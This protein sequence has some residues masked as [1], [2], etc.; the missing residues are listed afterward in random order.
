[1]PVPFRNRSTI[2]NAQTTFSGSPRNQ[3]TYTT[4]L[5]GARRHQFDTLAFPVPAG[6]PTVAPNEYVVHR[7]LSFERTFTAVNDTPPTATASNNYASKSV[8]NGSVIRNLQGKITVRNRS[9]IGGFVSVYR[10]ALSFYD[11]LIWDTVTPTTCPFT[12]DSTT[13]GP[14]DVRGVVAPKTVNSTRLA[15][16]NY[17]NLKTTQKYMEY[18][19]DVVLGTEDTDS[20]QVEI[21]IDG[22]PPKCVRSQTGMYYAYFLVNDGIK[23]GGESIT[24]DS[25]LEVSFEEIPSDNRL[26]FVQ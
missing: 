15:K 19:G 7:V 23:N 16:A 11:A 5:S 25:S 14:P 26:P 4:Q 12:F 6:Y 24:F 17:N 10:C 13:V 3:P 8:M 21:T 18:L 20:G 9:S 22:V 2:T 1:M